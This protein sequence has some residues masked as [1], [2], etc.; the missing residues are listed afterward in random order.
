MREGLLNARVR[1]LQMV[2]CPADTFS[3][4]LCQLQIVA[5]H[6]RAPTRQDYPTL[7]MDHCCAYVYACFL[8]YLVRIT[9][10]CPSIL[11]SICSVL[12]STSLMFFTTVP[13]LAFSVEPFTSSDLV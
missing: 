3:H 10:S 5:E 1:R 6:P 4:V 7:N 13:I 9:I 11:P 2:I 12:S 8:T